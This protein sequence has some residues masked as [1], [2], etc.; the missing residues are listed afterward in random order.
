[1]IDHLHGKVQKIADRVNLSVGDLVIDIGSNDGTL[2]QG[3]SD[4]GLHLV[5]TDTCGER[6]RQCYPE[7]IQL[8]PDFFSASSWRVN[9]SGWPVSCSFL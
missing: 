8:N 6:F 1:M 2:L 7:W 3:Y 5:G 9:V 4:I